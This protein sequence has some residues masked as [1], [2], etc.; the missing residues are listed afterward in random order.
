[1]RARLPG[2]G[3]RDARG[4]TR[5]G[6]GWQGA[7][8]GADQAALGVGFGATSALVWPPSVWGSEPSFAPAGR[9]EESGLCL[10]GL[11]LCAPGVGPLNFA[12]GRR[13]P[14]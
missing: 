14:P 10:V 3:G 7:A 13:S 1:M 9:E 11:G 6:C 2:L 12:V 4:R 5:L 8:L